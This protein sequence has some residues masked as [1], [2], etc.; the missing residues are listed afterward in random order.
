MFRALDQKME[1]QGQG[2][3]GWWMQNSFEMPVASFVMSSHHFSFVEVA[4]DTKDT[5]DTVRAKDRQKSQKTELASFP[6]QSVFQSLVCIASHDPNYIK[7]R[8][9]EGWSK[10]KNVLKMI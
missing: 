6:T 10:Q 4:F 3:I 9:T 1:R 2:L 8:V 5:I 7:N